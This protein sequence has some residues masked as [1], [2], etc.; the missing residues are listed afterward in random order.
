M[1]EKK[2]SLDQRSFDMGV[3]SGSNPSPE[4]DKKVERQQD[5]KQE[6]DNNF[7]SLEGAGDGTLASDHLLTGIP[8][9]SCLLALILTMFLIA[10][11]QT[12][13]ATILT[14]VGTKFNDFGKI[15]WIS[16]AFMLPMA[17]LS[18]TWGKLSIIVGRKY[19]ILAAIVWF[20]IGSLICAL[21]NSMTMLIV[22]RAIAGVGASGIQVLVMVII[23]EI[24]P[25]HK[26]GLAQSFLGAS[27]GL[28]SV[29]GPLVGGVFA[30][31]VSWR[32]CFYINLPFGGIAF[33]CIFCFFNPPFPKG[34]IL[35]KLKSIDYIGTFLLSTSLILILLALT[36][37]STDGSWNSALV[38][39]FFVVGGVLLMVFLT[40]NF[41]FSKDPLVPSNVI[42]VPSVLAGLVAFFFFYGAFMCLV[43]YTTI[44]FQVVLNKD[45]FGSGVSLLPMIIPL[46]IVSIATG[47]L[48]GKMRR[49]KIYILVGTGLGTLGSGLVS[50]FSTHT[51]LGKQ[52]G[53]LI[54]CGLGTGFLFQSLIISTQLN[55]PKANGGVLIATSLLALFRQLGGVIGSTVGQTIETVTFST[56]VG[57]DPTIPIEVSSR[58]NEFIN[59]PK[60]MQSLPAEIREKILQYFLL[61]FR[62][63]LYFAVGLYGAAFLVSTLTTNMQIPKKNNPNGSEKQADTVADMA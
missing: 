15:N 28:A 45:A 44:Y 24:V 5:S 47:I 21:A 6:D 22:G 56:K 50:M 59:S 19:S 43:L 35:K 7:K 26:R 54:I 63:T 38:I 31:Y 62:S 57:G 34:S 16:S 49:V 36:F 4:I 30:T 18:L 41:K 14:T 60:L 12:I 52:I 42:K 27:F 10:L 20:E 53:F 17:V 13:V 2:N 1:A 25:I 23:T 58:I 11:D 9:A 29:I 46:V 33:A 39:S 8:L 40:W 48:M 32:W 37:G 61:G 55:A 3:L 51:S